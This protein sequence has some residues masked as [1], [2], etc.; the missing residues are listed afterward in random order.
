MLI[1]FNGT[2]KNQCKSKNDYTKKSKL[3]SYITCS[4]PANTVFNATTNGILSQYLGTL[5]WGLHEV[6][7]TEPRS[8]DI[9]ERGESF[10]TGNKVC[11]SVMARQNHP[12]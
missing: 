7:L 9:S 2:K 8:N 5:Y 3:F 10:A 12:Y 1:F 6:E 11:T 4:A